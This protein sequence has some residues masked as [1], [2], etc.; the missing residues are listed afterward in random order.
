MSA[1]IDVVLGQKA[2]C[3]KPIHSPVKALQQEAVQGQRGGGGGAAVHGIGPAGEVKGMLGPSGCQCCHEATEGE[4]ARPGWPQL[5]IL[6]WAC[7][8]PGSTV[9]CE[10]KPMIAYGEPG[11]TVHLHSSSMH[12]IITIYL[13]MPAAHGGQ[14]F[15]PLSM[16]F[17]NLPEDIWVPPCCM[18][19]CVHGTHWT[20]R[21]KPGGS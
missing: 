16:G 10:H 5:L 8:E 3:G 18:H 14:L 19:L 21:Q 15:S 7:G 17:G 4:G 11:S 20:W 13:H 12:P 2:W 6:H 9:H 1:H